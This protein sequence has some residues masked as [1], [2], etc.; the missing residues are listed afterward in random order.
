MTYP[1]LNYLFG[2]APKTN[3]NIAAKSDKQIEDLIE[4]AGR[5]KVFSRAR[6]LGWVNELP[7]KWVWVQIAL[8]LKREEAMQ[9]GEP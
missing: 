9:V 3:E 8:E 6:S 2:P 5:D 7:P 4:S 1:D